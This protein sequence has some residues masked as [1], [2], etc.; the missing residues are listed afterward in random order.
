MPPC[1]LLILP[2]MFN[3]GFSM[4]PQI[5]GNSAFQSGAAFMHSLAK[6]YRTAVC[7]SMIAEDR[8][9]Y[10]NRLYFIT[11]D[12]EEYC[13]DKRHLFKLAGEDQYYSAGSERMI[14]EYMGW[15]I[16]PLI[17]YDL[18]FPVWSRQIRGQEYDLLL[19]VANWPQRRSHAWRTLLPARAIE[20]MCYVAG[21]NRVGYDIKGIYHAG[22]SAIYDVLGQPIARAAE[23][24]EGVVS[25][26]V[27]LSELIDLR[28]SL[29]FLNDA[30]DF[31]LVDAV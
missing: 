13:Y 29:G 12:G 11:S 16:C 10:Y 2:E 25:S 22:E 3:T 6:R 19:Y 5:F 26:V 17:C 28:V 24:E 21:V 15:K 1:Q 27:L 20:N 14:I 23:G 8:G 4:E 31:Q 9:R 30:D 18:R 7:G